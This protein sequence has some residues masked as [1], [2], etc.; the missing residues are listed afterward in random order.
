MTEVR[1]GRRDWAAFLEFGVPN[2]VPLDDLREH[3]FSFGC[4]CAPFE[5]EGVCVHNSLDGRERF[6]RVERLPS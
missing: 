3:Q 4:W 1:A 2:V 5:E 6:E